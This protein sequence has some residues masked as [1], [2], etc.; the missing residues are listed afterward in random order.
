MLILLETGLRLENIWK[1]VSA[2]AEKLQKS[3]VFLMKPEDLFHALISPMNSVIHNFG[4]LVTMALL[5]IVVAT[6]P[7]SKWL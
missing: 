2:K 5:V 1:K 7:L 3:L 6:K 4:P